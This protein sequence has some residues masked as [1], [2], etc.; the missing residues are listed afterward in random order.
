MDKDVE[1]EMGSLVVNNNTD[2]L[3]INLQGV[4]NLVSIDAASYLSIQLDVSG[5]DNRA[6]VI[7]AA[8]DSQ[9]ELT[10][11]DNEVELHTSPEGSVSK[12][13][14]SGVDPYL[15]VEGTL[16]R[17]EASG[18]GDFSLSG[19]DATL[20]LN[21][22]TCQSVKTSGVDPS[23]DTSTRTVSLNSFSCLAQ[24]KV[25]K[26]SSSCG[27]D[28]DW[29]TWQIIGMSLGTLAVVGLC[30]GGCLYCCGCLKRG[31]RRGEQPPQLFVDKSGADPEAVAPASVVTTTAAPVMATVTAEPMIP[32]A[33]VIEVKSQPYNDDDTTDPEQ[34][35]HVTGPQ[36]KIY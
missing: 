21:G 15:L 13:R 4:D 29:T 31:R 1:I 12:I 6:R 34:A 17:D 20:R 25:V 9:V 23:C 36:A 2:P 14:M 5:V 22:D 35:I 32:E 16:D 27:W 7:G 19:V 10:G 8:S 24:S 11:A 3:M 26:Y 28:C 18:D 33:Q 30:L